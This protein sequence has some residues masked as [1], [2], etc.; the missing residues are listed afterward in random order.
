MNY[1]NNGFLRE[2][3]LCL[4][5]VVIHSQGS[6]NYFKYRANEWIFTSGIVRMG[7]DNDKT[8]LL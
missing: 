8:I 1:H 2:D 4:H 3:T 5:L 7:I 6:F